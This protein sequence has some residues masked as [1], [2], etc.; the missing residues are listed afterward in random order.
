[1]KSFLKSSAALALA[2]AVLVAATGLG[3]DLRA[4]GVPCNPAVQVCS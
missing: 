1:M 3:A 2:L 4:Q